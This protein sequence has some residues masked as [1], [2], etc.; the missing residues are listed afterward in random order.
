MCQMRELSLG[1]VLLI[2][3]TN[4]GCGTILS[5]MATTIWFKLPHAFMQVSSP[6]L[7]LCQ[8]PCFL[9]TERPSF[10]KSASLAMR[11]V[12][13]VVAGDGDDDVDCADQSRSCSFTTLS[14]GGGIMMTRHTVAQSENQSQVQ[15]ATAYC[16]FPAKSE[17]CSVARSPDSF[18]T[19]PGKRSDQSVNSPRMRCAMN[20]CFYALDPAFPGKKLSESLRRSSCATNEPD[21]ILTKERRERGRGVDCQIGRLNSSLRRSAPSSRSD[22]CLGKQSWTDGA[23]V[24]SC[25]DDAEIRPK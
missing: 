14:R 19:S 4:K 9:P 5:L 20:D 8:S 10:Q 15:R 21:S 25:A 2:K 1:F 22:N 24:I 18:P 6:T 13:A 7:S 23:F 12:A 17:R 11:I 3:D 16:T